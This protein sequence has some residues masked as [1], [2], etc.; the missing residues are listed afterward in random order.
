MKTNSST[1]IPRVVNTASNF[2]VVESP[3]FNTIERGTSNTERIGNIIGPCIWQF[4]FSADLIAPGGVAPI[5]QAA[6]LRVIVVQYKAS[7]INIAN[8][9]DTYLDP[10]R[11]FD[12]AVSGA[13]AHLLPLRE[14]ITALLS[15]LC[16]K[17]YHL[18][19]NA[20][21]SSMVKKFRFN[22]ANLRWPFDVDGDEFPAN[23]VIV[24]YFVVKGASEGT[25][26]VVV[27]IQ[28]LNMLR[29]YDA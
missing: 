14:G 10:T 11:L 13:N 29:Y 2:V 19:N 21:T 3:T 12:H 22:I 20:S 16:D 9:P 17:T 8:P 6:Y 7:G 4:R 27:N 18:D 5:D 15:V 28:S 24:Y 1:V 26:N 25:E 23:P